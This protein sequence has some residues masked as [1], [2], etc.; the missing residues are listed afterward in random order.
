MAAP[1]LSIIIPAL[2]EEAA[3]PA[4]LA[5]LA[6]L[7]PAPHEILLVDGGSTDRTTALAREAGLTVLNHAPPGRAGQMNAGAASATGDHLA[8]LHADTLP[9]IDLAATIART[10]AN[11]RTAC[12]GFVSVMR[13][14]RQ[15]RWLT[16]THNFIKTWY[17]PLLFRP[18]SFARGARLLFGDQ[19]IFCRA[20]DFRAIGGFDPNQS[21]MEEADF[22]LRMVRAGR[23]RVRQT[24]RLVHS[25]DRRVAKWGGL[26]ANLRYIEVGVKWGLGADSSRLAARY[27]DVR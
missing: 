12:A 10:L 13:G 22:I 26:R 11:P 8:F 20:G 16:T 14:P 6:A 2:N 21:I 15:T 27:E 1:R 18:I 7:D 25:S 24:P 23:G 17:A 19:L 3:L 4:T 9:P 5:R